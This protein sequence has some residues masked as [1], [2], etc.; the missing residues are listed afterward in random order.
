MNDLIVIPQLKKSFIARIKNDVITEIARIDISFNSKSI[1]TENKLIVSLCFDTKTLSVHNAL[2]D[3]LLKKENVNYTSINTKNNIVYLGGEYFN[4][5]EMFSVLNLEEVNFKINTIDFPIKVEKWKSI[6]DILINGTDLILVDNI[7]F[8]KYLIKFDISSPE[9]PKH[10]ETLELPNNGVYEHIIKGDINN[11]WMVLFSSTAGRYCSAQHITISGKTEKYLYLH[12]HFYH[13]DGYKSN[14]VIDNLSYRYTDI[15]LIKNHLY[16]LRTDGLGYID[17]NKKIS[18]EKFKF[19]QTTNSN[20]KRI[21][22]YQNDKLIAICEN[23]YELI[24]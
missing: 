16:I 12:K 1:I 8:P 15:A 14:K 19:I 13:Y 10:I 21:I 7:V 4:K 20:I 18:D 17:L 24:K 9:I 2:G 23:G 6:D 11:D 5:G 3:L 22:K